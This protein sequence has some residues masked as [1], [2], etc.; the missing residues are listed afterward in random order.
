MKKIIFALA[1]L[2]LAGCGGSSPQFVEADMGHQHYRGR[3]IAES[4]LVIDHDGRSQVTEGMLNWNENVNIPFLF[5]TTDDGQRDTIEINA[6]TELRDADYLNQ[7]GNTTIT[8]NPDGTQHCVINI[9]T[10]PS[11]NSDTSKG[12]E[13]PNWMVWAQQLGH[14]IGFADSEDPESIMY[15]GSDSVIQC[16][17][18]SP[19]LLG[20]FNQE[21]VSTGR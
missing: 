14:C 21:R 4:Y 16:A 15:G 7:Q 13:S 1:F 3:G 2:A 6:V 8:Y 10:T 18:F 12:P 17:E 9:I 5:V 11:D 19:D 20:L